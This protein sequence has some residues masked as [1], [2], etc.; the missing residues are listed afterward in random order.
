[1]GTR[2]FI[3]YKLDFGSVNSNS[4]NGKIYLQIKRLLTE[5]GLQNEDN[6]ANEQDGNILCRN[7]PSRRIGRL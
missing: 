1:M 4:P 7:H 3:A 2:S 5:K 6:F